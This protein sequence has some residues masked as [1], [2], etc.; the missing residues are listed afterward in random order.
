MTFRIAQISDTH[1]S[2]VKPF[3]VENFRSLGPWLRAARPDLVLNSGDISLDGAGRE[4]DLSAA[5][6]LHDEIGLTVRYIPGNH[7]VGDN[8]DVPDRHG[9]PALSEDRLAAYRRHY[10]EDW[11]LLD[12]PGWRIIALN[13]QL[14]GSA[15]PDA[16]AQ[17]EF[18]AGAVAGAAGRAIALF[19]HKP[20]FDRQA[21][22]AEI[23]GRFLNPAPRQSLLRHL[24]ARPPSLVASGHVHQYR[25][26]AQGLARAI[27]APST[28]FVVPASFQPIYGLKQVGYVEH[29]L[30][31]DGTH[32]SG[33]VQPGGMKTLDIIDFKDAY[34]ELPPPAEP[35]AGM[36]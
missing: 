9:Q 22:E 33:F 24:A 11:W 1:L 26:S 3:F 2:A 6:A 32:D 17:E 15:F 16:A 30:H 20:L 12:V 4:E 18:L 5:K 8:L 34:G 14:A 7:D 36:L 13:T 10:G 35:T 19:V 21:D 29:R 25:S 27:W 31:P 23:G 28:A